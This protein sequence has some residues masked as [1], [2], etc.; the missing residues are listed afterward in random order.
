MADIEMAI[1]SIRVSLANQQ[2]VV[3][4]HERKTNRYLPI[5]VGPE[6]ADSI[7]MK[8]QNVNV[9]RP[10]THDMTCSIIMAM[11]GR[12][13]S[14]VINRIE[15]DT[16]YARL[17]IKTFWGKKEIDC[18]PSDAIAMAVRQH[19]PIFANDRVL[20]IAGI[21]LT[22][23]EEKD[24]SGSAAGNNSAAVPAVHQI[25]CPNCQG[26]DIFVGYLNYD[27][28]LCGTCYHKFT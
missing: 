28:K 10:I 19:V 24:T 23:G 15:S 26:T 14:A 20:K 5:W 2:H 21:T 22:D 13:K 8:L 1:D 27:N 17:I 9:P 3:I 4:L 12:V 25:R 18:R 7:S 6:Q 11:G 16:I